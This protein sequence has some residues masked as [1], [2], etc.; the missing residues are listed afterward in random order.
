MA[1]TAPSIKLPALDRYQL[2]ECIGRGGMAEV[3]RGLHQ[4]PGGFE[5]EV[6]VKVLLPQ[7][8]RE[9][10]F[11]DMLLDEAR[12][13][14]SLDHPSIV[15]VLD[16]GE[17]GDTFFIVM[18]YV[19]GPDLR[20]LARGVRRAKLP[21]TLSLYVVSEVL[22][23]LEVVH[24]AHSADGR[25]LRIVHRDISPNNVML[26]ERGYVKLG[27]FGI[28]HA[29]SRLTET[30]IGSIKGKSR[31]M[32]PEQFRGGVLDR[33]ADLYAVGVT[34]FE[35]L[36]G[37]DARRSS[38]LSP[39]GPVFTWPQNL[40][41]DEVPEDVVDILRRALAVDPADRYVDAGEFRR[42]VAYALHQRHPDYGVDT[43]A[44]HL[45]DLKN[46]RAPKPTRPLRVLPA[47]T[48]IDPPVA[49]QTASTNVT[50][51]VSG[52]DIIV[53][54]KTGPALERPPTSPS[55]VAK[56][57]HGP[58]PRG[59]ELFDRWVEWV[60]SNRIAVAFVL[61]GLLLCALAIAVVV[62][63][64][65]PSSELP[66]EPKAVAVSLESVSPTSLDVR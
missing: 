28:A 35:A 24:E 8:A 58:L 4:G 56:T 19:R 61:L 31:Y 36:L 6:A 14:G 65:A 63:L 34:L 30:R 51:A 18:E 17:Q 41:D 42:D 45:R 3:Y 10:E 1:R 16:V 49:E 33:R 15:Q 38:K 9:R 53:L 23:A 57:A 46:G 29:V 50:I 5:R 66:S 26:D 39:F 47:K 12:I 40:S 62:A 52:S 13:A 59:M 55:H 25:H 27:D 64:S 37:E 54:D 60:R 21:L 20:T 2:V 43:L 32:A 7:F 44:Q 11:I 48:T 22:R